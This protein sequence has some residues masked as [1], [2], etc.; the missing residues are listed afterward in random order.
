MLLITKYWHKITLFMAFLCL[1][2]KVMLISFDD[3]T[4]P[5]GKQ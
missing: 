1:A 4:T 3:K 2:A 5:N